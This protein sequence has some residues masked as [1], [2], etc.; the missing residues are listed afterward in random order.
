MIKKEKDTLE[1]ISVLK[2]KQTQQ[3]KVDQIRNQMSALQNRI[4][5]KLE[6]MNLQ[7]NIQKMKE[8]LKFVSNTF[9][10]AI[11]SDKARKR[12]HSQL[13]A[14]LSDDKIPTKNEFMQVVTPEILM[15]DIEALTEKV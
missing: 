2:N 15:E 1:T 13:Q 6:V 8:L 5:R 12:I 14:R 9:I 4:D 7:D 10:P 3:K 11:N